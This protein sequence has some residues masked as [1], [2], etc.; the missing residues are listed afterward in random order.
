MFGRE[1]TV[2]EG[3]SRAYEYVPETIIARLDADL[4][5]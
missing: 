2:D 3:K 4:K 1:C 5:V